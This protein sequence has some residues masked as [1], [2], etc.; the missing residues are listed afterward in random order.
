MTDRHQLVTTDA[1]IPLARFSQ[2][3]RAGQIVQASGQGSLDPETGTVINLG[4]VRA[5][6]LQ[7]LKL[8]EAILA[9]GGATFRDAVMVRVYLTDRAHF[10]EMNA[11]YEEFIADR[12]GDGVPPSRTTLFV[13]LP[14]DGML[15]EIDAMAVV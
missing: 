11:A 12:V 4:D 8:V 14:L 15:V 13:G 6:T 9:A 2:G 5:Q 7:T 1:P 3:V 10:G